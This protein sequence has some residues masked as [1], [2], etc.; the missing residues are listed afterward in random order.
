[1]DP[2]VKYPHLLGSLCAQITIIIYLF[3]KQTKYVGSDII[4]F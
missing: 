2:E 3:V 1:M 4:H